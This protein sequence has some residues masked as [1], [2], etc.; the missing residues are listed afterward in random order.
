[1][2]LTFEATQIADTATISQLLKP[3]DKFLLNNLVK[4]LGSFEKQVQPCT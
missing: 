2:F 4:V 1:M 3:L